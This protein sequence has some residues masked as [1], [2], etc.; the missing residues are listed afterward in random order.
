PEGFLFLGE[1]E[2]PAQ[3]PEL[4]AGFD[5]EHH[6]YRA[7][8]EQET[9]P[10][11]TQPEQFGF[12]PD[13]IESVVPESEEPPER[14]FGELHRQ[15]LLARYSPPSILVDRDYRLV[16]VIG[17]VRPYLA[18][19]PGHSTGNV[20]EMVSDEFRPEL[21]SLLVEA[22][23]SDGAPVRRDFEIEGESVEFRATPIESDLV[24]L[25]FLAEPG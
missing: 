4:F 2:S 7:S 11:Y 10:L 20:L 1:S 16:H 19:R 13:Q 18:V 23:Q 24:E 22:F 6:I 21:R 8:S 5:D 17:D 3:K 15:T 14:D 25:T 12:D 9:A